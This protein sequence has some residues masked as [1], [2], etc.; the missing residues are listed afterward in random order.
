MALGAS[1][2]DIL[3]LVVG[4]VMTRTGI[5]LAIGLVVALALTRFISSQLFEVSANDSRTFVGVS[6]GL[7]IV[8]LAACYLPA[9]RS[10]KIDPMEALRNE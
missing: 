7:V 2:F 6:V 4:W 8:A 9:R 10:A 1:K 3:R 5:G